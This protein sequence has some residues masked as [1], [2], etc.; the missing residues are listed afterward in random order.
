M[1]LCGLLLRLCSWLMENSFPKCQTI[2]PSVIHQIFSLFPYNQ[3]Y[4]SKWNI[5]LYIVKDWSDS[6]GNIL[7]WLEPSEL[8]LFSLTFNFPW[9]STLFVR[10]LCG[11]LLF[12]IS[13]LSGWYLVF[14]NW[15]NGLSGC[16]DL[17]VYCAYTWR[18][19][20]KTN[21]NHAQILAPCE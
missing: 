16:S 18:L 5:I 11:R 10:K 4:K 14:L 9:K 12:K 15:L 8:P 1:F 6:N 19:V 13:S 17:G 21:P 7:A 20:Q 3:R 2:R